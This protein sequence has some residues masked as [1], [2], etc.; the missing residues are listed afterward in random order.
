M[1]GQELKERRLKLKLTQNGL[2]NL[3][4]VTTNKVYDWKLTD[5]LF[6]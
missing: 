1:N 5:T 3:L 2:S 6:Q 4:G